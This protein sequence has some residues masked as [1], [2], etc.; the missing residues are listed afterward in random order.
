MQSILT[1]QYVDYALKQINKYN[2][3]IIEAI[4][5]CHLPDNVASYL[6]SLKTKPNDLNTLLNTLAQSLKNDKPISYSWNG[7]TDEVV[8]PV[9][10][11]KAL[12]EFFISKEYHQYQKAHVEYITICD[13]YKN[14][15]I[16]QYKNNCY[17]RIKALDT[18]EMI[19]APSLP[20]NYATIIDDIRPFYKIAITA[21]IEEF[22]NFI[23]QSKVNQ[24]EQNITP[25]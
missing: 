23:K 10:T 3:K 12:E 18:H 20:E 21:L 7:I 15:C 6:K 25:Q 24:I 1:S 19:K 13:N 22:K 4:L 5:K 16:V 14:N 8:L 9:E 11:Q 2:D 17:K